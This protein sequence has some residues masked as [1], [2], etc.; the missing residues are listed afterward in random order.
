[1]PQP[2]LSGV[3]QIDETFIREAQKGSRKLTS[4]IDKK[5]VREPRY[6]YRPSKLGVMGPE[7]ATV[8]TAVDNSGHCVCYVTG[9][10]KL[11]ADI[12]IDLFE[13]H[14]INPGYI[15]TDS[16]Q[17]YREYCNLFNINHYERP[18]NYLKT[19]TDNGYVTPTKSDE[20]L[21]KAQIESNNK[22]KEKLYKEGLIDCISNKGYLDYAEFKN[23]KADNSL[24]L[25]R[26]NELHS[27]IKEFIYKDRTNVST[28]Y[29]GDYLG[30][31]SFIH[32]WRIDNGHFPSSHSD[33]EKIFIEILRHQISYTTKDLKS[34]KI[35]LPKP[36]SRY[37]TL[38]KEKTK[39]ARKVLKNKYFKF[40]EEDNVIDF[41]KRK[42]LSDQPKS[43][44][45]QI[46]K[47][48][49]IKNYRKWTTWSI[50]TCIMKLS[51]ISEIILQLIKQNRYYDVA[52]EDEQ[53]NKVRKYV[54]AMG[55]HS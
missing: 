53:Y 21:S 16:N 45:Q 22:I 34:T 33:A 13:E 30:F 26:V 9:L 47:E 37:I 20:V 51:N 54:E 8:T 11:T 48:N 7:F 25:G 28:K 17:V 23:I 42:F 32:N 12:F 19:L 44:L 10:G 2:K 55:L 31:F 35:N 36:A 15:C 27:E 5:D 52:Y 49:G 50:I 14:L 39:E 4:Y 41:D 3:V 24:S 40:D 38:L 1:M 18:S 6:G 29:L 43:K 46:C